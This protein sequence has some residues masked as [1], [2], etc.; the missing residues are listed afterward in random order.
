MT[1]NRPHSFTKL[2]GILLSMVRY[3]WVAAIAAT[4]VAVAVIV[5]SFQK[6]PPVALNLVHNTRIDITPE[7]I[8]SLRKIGQWEFLSVTT[9][10]LVEWHRKG[11]FSDDHLI[12]IYSGTLDRKS[13]V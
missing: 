1:Q 4:A 2:G 12:R 13:V 3:W 7:E 10:E 11:T 6:N 5:K 8:R 9:E